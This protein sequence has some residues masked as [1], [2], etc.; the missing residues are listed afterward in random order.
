MKDG[1]RTK[2]FDYANKVGSDTVVFVAPTEWSKGEIVVKYLR[3]TDVT[4]KQ[5]TIDLNTY[6]SSL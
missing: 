2:A 3:E 5:I 1:K 6:L 4:K